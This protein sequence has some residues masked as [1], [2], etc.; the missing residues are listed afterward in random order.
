MACRWSKSNTISTN[1][2]SEQYCRL[3]AK[4]SFGKRWCPCCQTT[5]WWWL[6]S[7]N[8]EDQGALA[9]TC[10]RREQN[11]DCGVRSITYTWERPSSQVRATLWQM[12]FPVKV[13]GRLH[14]KP[15]KK[16]FL[17]VVRWFN[18]S[19]GWVSPWSACLLHQAAS[20]CIHNSQGQW[21]HEAKE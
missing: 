18:D 19:T 7:T 5:R 6:A 9:Y 14:C 13:P 12:P 4:H 21:I 11:C 16:W 2:G 15:L 1:W 3:N 17:E 20:F 8:K 10:T